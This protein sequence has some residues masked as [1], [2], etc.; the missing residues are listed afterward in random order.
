VSKD[1]INWDKVKWTEFE[2]ASYE[3]LSEAYLKYKQE[4]GARVFKNSIYQ[5]EVSHQQHPPPFGHVV[6]LSIKTRDKQ[7]RHDW[8]ELQRIKNELVGEEVEAVELYPA[9]SRL[10]DTSNQYHLYCFP[11]LQFE[12]QKFPFGYVE[13]LVAEGSTANIAITGKGSRQRDFRPELRPKDVVRGEVLE[14][15]ISAG[16]PVVGSCPHDNTPFVMKAQVII[17]GITFFRGEC[18][19]G[20]HAV[21]TTDKEAFDGRRQ[22]GSAG[23]HGSGDAPNG[24]RSSG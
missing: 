23:D 16:L 22:E 7:P 4:M 3:G 17:E 14:K 15:A 1:K 13:R 18:L 12:S 10:V 2:E 20:L 24:V 19:K 8:R 21:L 6:Y 9:E 11:E 5:V